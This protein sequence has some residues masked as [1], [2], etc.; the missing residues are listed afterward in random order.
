MRVSAYHKY[1]ARNC[2]EAHMKAYSVLVVFAIFTA[3]AFYVVWMNRESE[4]IVTA[5]F[6]IS[7]AALIGVFL[8]VFLFGGEVPVT[9]NFP[10]VFLFRI[11]DWEPLAPPDRP[12]LMSLFEVPT[13]GVEHPELMKDNDNGATLYHHLLQKAII[14]RLAFLYGSSWEIDILDFKTGMGQQQGS[15]PSPEAIGPSTKLS[16]AQVRGLLKG[17]RFA[18]INYFTAPEIALPPGTALTIR[19]PDT[20]NVGM[21]EITLKNDFVTL[22]IKTAYFSWMRSLGG[23][24]VLM[25]YSW[26]QDREFA[27]AQYF[28]TIRAD[29]SRLRSGHP[30]MAKYK[31]WVN[32]IVS[33][34]RAQ[35]DEQELW[36]NTREN[37]VFRKQLEQYSGV[38]IPISPPFLAPIPKK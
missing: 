24:R 15:Q 38:A 20:A 12:Q 8:T 26:E 13:L 4:K 18:D 2:A 36:S 23:Y 11:S 29:F 25:G 17:N 37:Y 34:L 30:Q 35:F 32:Q 21:G 22:S 14:E 1:T 10:A 19:A 28:V 27:S 9:A 3:L 31:R 6:P 7:V 33:D 5:V 16:T